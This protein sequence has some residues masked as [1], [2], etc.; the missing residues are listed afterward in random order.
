LPFRPGLPSLKHAASVTFDTTRDR[1]MPATCATLSSKVST[2]LRPKGG[3][4]PIIERPTT[5]SSISPLFRIP[6]PCHPISV[7]ASNA[8]APKSFADTSRDGK[9]P[10]TSIGEQSS[11]RHRRLPVSMIGIVCDY[12]T[13][14]A[15]KRQDPNLPLSFSLVLS[16][17]PSPSFLVHLALF[18]SLTSDNK[19]RPKYVPAKPP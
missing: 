14:Y 1:R 19:R 18:L 8:V 11:P 13:R 3:T 4:N 9:S 5:L 7:C 10:N 15:W 2:S 17:S 6:I 16:V 12:V